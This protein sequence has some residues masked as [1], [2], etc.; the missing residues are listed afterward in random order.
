M[1]ATRKIRGKTLSKPEPLPGPSTA[2]DS[3]IE[4]FDSDD[5]IKDKDYVM[6]DSDKDGYSHDSPS[7]VCENN[8]IV[9]VS[10]KGS[11]QK[12]K[13][14]SKPIDKPS[15]KN[16]NLQPGVKNSKGVIASTPKKYLD[17]FKYETKEGAKT[18]VCL[19]CENLKINTSIKMK[20][21]NTKGLKY[22]LSKNHPT[23]FSMFFGGDNT[24]ITKQKQQKTISQMFSF[25]SE[26]AKT[27]KRVSCVIIISDVM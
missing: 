11:A 4:P 2:N 8:E 12:R 27:S 20:G 18:G 9:E 17:Y 7:D 21:G 13:A 3:D 6:D 10:S 22:H 16:T 23:E 25:E 19:I 14:V 24:N 15:K 5:S 26:T 1:K